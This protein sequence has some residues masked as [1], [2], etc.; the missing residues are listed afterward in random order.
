MPYAEV[1]VNAA[2]PHRRAFSYSVPE[3]MRLEVGQAV[4]VPFGRRTLQGIV[5]EL[6][7]V[8]SYP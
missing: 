3:G 6:P 8:P 4:Y 1:A 2:L 5:L 7:E